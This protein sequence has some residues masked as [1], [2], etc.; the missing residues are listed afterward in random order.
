MQLSSERSLAISLLTLRLLC[1]DNGGT[2]FHSKISLHEQ[3][4]IEDAILECSRQKHQV[5]RDK[6]LNK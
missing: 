1:R 4:S 6:T 2:N 5:F 3:Y